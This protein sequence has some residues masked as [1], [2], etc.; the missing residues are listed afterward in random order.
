MQTEHTS[1]FS[2]VGH[3][4]HEVVALKQPRHFTAGQERVHSLQE[5]SVK[6]IGLVEDEAH[7]LA[8]APGA[9]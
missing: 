7:T 9:L 3:E 2:N 1:C 8:V 5:S 6:D 4:G